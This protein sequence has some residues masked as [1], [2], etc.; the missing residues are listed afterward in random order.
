MTAG[1]EFVKWLKPFGCGLFILI[2]IIFL[3]TCFTAKAPLEGYT[4]PHDSEYY[5]EH[6]DELENE[7]ETNMFPRLEGIEDCRIEGDKLTIIID[8]EHFEETSKI[9]T[10]YYGQDLFDL[11]TK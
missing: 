10:H 3:I 9:I 1:Q 2:F 6:L 8:G 11:K 5:A 4:V 7:L